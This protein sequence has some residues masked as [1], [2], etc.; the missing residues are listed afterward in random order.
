MAAVVSLLAEYP[1]EVVDRVCDP[2]TGIAT[3]CKFLPTIAE[4]SEALKSKMFPH[5]KAWMAEWRRRQWEPV[6]REEP[7]Q[8]QIDRVRKISETLKSLGPRDP[9]EELRKE[10]RR[11]RATKPQGAT[12]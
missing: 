12:I 11:L 2:R 9:I 4:L 8:E 3:A 10:A 6:N 7:T 5:N 1:Q